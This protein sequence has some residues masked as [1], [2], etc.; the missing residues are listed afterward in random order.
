MLVSD[1]DGR[2]LT[3]K[4]PKI[5]LSDFINIVAALLVESRHTDSAFKD[6]GPLAL[7]IPRSLVSCLDRLMI[8]VWLRVAIFGYHSPIVK[9]RWLY[10]TSR[11]Y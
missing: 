4:V 7:D 1:V 3:R 9:L 11:R 2:I 5:T 6:V 8:C 10:G